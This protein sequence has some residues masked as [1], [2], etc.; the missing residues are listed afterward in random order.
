MG[1]ASDEQQRNAP[2]LARL[3]G[4]ET[5]VD[6]IVAPPQGAISTISSLRLEIVTMFRF[7][8]DGICELED[9]FPK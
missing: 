9:P 7:Q 4:N 8:I 3:K 5:S 6:F 2:T 1:H